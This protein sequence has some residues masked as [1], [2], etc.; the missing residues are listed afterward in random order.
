[1]PH[2]P[3]PKEKLERAVKIY[4]ANGGNM[5]AS[6]REAGM[7]RKSFYY[8]ILKAK[9][10]GLMD[11]MEMHDANVPLRDDYLAARERKLQAYQRKKRKGDWRKPVMLKLAPQPIA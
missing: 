5:S 2:P 8:H 1:M 10:R 4:R 9:E 6:A 11:D 3:I 7:I